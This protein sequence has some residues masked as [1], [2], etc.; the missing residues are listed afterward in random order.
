MKKIT[1]TISVLLMFTCVSGQINPIQNLS[2]QHWYNFSSGCPSYNCFALNWDEPEPSV[3]D[4]LIGYNI[5]RDNQLWRFQNFEGAG[6]GEMTIPPCPYENFWNFFPQPFWIKV[7]AVYNSSH[8]ESIAI[9]SVESGEFMVNIFSNT[10]VGFQI[11]ENPVNRG[12]DLIIRFSDGMKKCSII[13]IYDC[14]GRIVSVLKLSKNE[15]LVSIPTNELRS[16]IYNAVFIFEN[17]ITSRKII[18]L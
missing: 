7:K 4:T 1:F 2:Y 12:D 13:R 15:N 5:Y 16:G 8:I 10:I 6:C 11:V 14:E 9:D 17:E 3:Q 18:L